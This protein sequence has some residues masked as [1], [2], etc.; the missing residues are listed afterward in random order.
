VGKT[1]GGRCEGPKK[2]LRGAGYGGGKKRRE[3]KKKMPLN[4]PPQ[5]KKGWDDNV[6]EVFGGIDQAARKAT[7]IDGD[8]AVRRKKGGCSTGLGMETGFRKTILF[9]MWGGAR[10]HHREGER[11]KDWGGGN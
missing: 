8:V 4:I 3:Q 1:G 7:Y 11:R 6:G 2:G 5:K 10:W 9:L